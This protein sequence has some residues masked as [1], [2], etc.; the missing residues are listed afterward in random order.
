MTK[1]TLFIQKISS[2]E[3]WYLLYCLQ[4]DTQVHV[5]R[6]LKTAL[7][8]PGFKVICVYAILVLDFVR[9]F[10]WFTFQGTVCLLDGFL[11]DCASNV[12]L[13]RWVL[14]A[15]QFSIQVLL[16]ETHDAIKLQSAVWNC[17]AE[18]NRTF[19]QNWG[20]LEVSK[21]STETIY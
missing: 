18:T 19:S 3:I 11:L 14:Q 17:P 20:C 5:Y 10:I 1:V 12:L 2:S 7:R 6:G 4:I 13:C 21:Y 16:S 15:E 8:Y 9:C